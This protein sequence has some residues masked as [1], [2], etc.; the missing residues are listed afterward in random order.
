[1]SQA[2]LFPTRIAF[3]DAIGIVDRVAAAHRVPAQRVALAR[4]HGCILA[5][6]VT[7]R[8]A[9][10][11]FDNSAMDG[12][13]LRHADLH[14][15]DETVLRLVG[16]QFAGRTVDLGIAAGECARITTGAPLP[17][18]TD[19]VVMKEN[20]RLDGERVVVLVVPESGQHVR[21]AGEDMQ[22]GQLLLRAGEP[23]T[24][25]RIALAAS[26]G[27]AELEVARRPT[28]AVFTTGDELVEPGLPL[29]PGQIYNS[30]REQLMGLLRADG[31]EPVAWPTLPDDPAQV[32][33]ALRHAGH[34]FDLVLTC[35]AVSAGEKDHIPAL[36]GAQGAIHFWKVR[37]KPG[38]PVLLADGGGLGSALFLCLPGNPVSVLATYLALGRPLL[39]AMQGRTCARPRWRA[40]MA[41]PWHKAHERLEFLR[42][43]LRSSGEGSL[44]VEP[45]P[46]DGSH[47]MQAAADSD[48]L[49]VLADGARQYAAG[50]IVD[51]L[52]Y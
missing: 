28:V 4:A 5:H 25:A 1:M 12:F 51:V 45:N 44:E 39:D 35:G 3:A 31:L 22:P 9:Q 2:S 49:I 40:R 33:S 14:A 19:T 29:A 11:P 26:Q 8:I 34:A 6:D 17:A 18:G 42:G 27:L 52:P 50:T 48:A 21:R 23:L 30:N 20:T 43:R 16:E 13:A 7:A 41:A 37:M 10:P 47:R 32:E 15:G 46:A 38:M 36:L 24:P